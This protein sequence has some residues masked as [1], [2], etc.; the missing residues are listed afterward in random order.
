[1]FKITFKSGRVMETKLEVKEV[2]AR[3]DRLYALV[4]ICEAYEGC[5]ASICAKALKAAEK[6][7][8]FTGIIRLT[9]TEKEFLSYLLEGSMGDENRKV[10]DFYTK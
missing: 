6:N 8:N 1:M 7:N 3:L 2:I 10:V 9:S 5:G 4:S